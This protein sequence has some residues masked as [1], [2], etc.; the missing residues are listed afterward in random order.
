[1]IDQIIDIIISPASVEEGAEVV[2]IPLP[3]E[4]GG[5]LLQANMY[6]I[7]VITCVRV[8]TDKNVPCRQSEERSQSL[9]CAR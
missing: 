7:T 8:C 5:D 4:A 9:G 2:E 1:M 6:H 3:S